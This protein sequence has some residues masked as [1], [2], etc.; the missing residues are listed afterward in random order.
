MSRY[1]VCIGAALIDELFYASEM[2]MMRTTNN[3]IVKRSPGGVSRNIAH[4]LSLLE[5]PVQLISIFGN[6]G[7]AL[8]L[9]KLCLDVG[10]QLD[11][12]FNA[13]ER[14]GK[15]TGLID[16]DGSLFTALFTNSLEHFITPDFLE[17]RRELLLN[18]SYLLLDANLPINSMEWLIAFSRHNNIPLII[19]PVSVEPARKLV[20]I[21]FNGLYMVTPNEDELPAMTS[22][23]DTESQVEELLQ[24]GV[25]YVWL[26]R[27]PEGSVLYNRTQTLSLHAPKARVVD[28]TGAGDGSVTGFIMARLAGLDNRDALKT[29]HTL[30]AEILQVSGAV[31]SHIN[32]A[33]LLQKVSKYYTA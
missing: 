9:R 21:D 2:M 24:R 3:V 14:N 26:H 29:A 31:A 28:C 15:Y 19:E 12:S 25:E 13:E 16:A 7:D 18:A 8:W 5:V 10:V 4:Q 23:E 33:Q 32:Q 6:D 11:G 1:V 30:A 27:G 22:A 17:E 20:N